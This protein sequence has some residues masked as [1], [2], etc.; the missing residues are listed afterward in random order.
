MAGDTDLQTLSC[1]ALLDDLAGLA[2]DETLEVAELRSR[3]RGL[4]APDAP[5]SSDPREGRLTANI[6]VSYRRA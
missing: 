1:Q 4:I 3:L 2:G 6:F 5:L